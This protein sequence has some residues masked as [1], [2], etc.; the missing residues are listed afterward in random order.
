LKLEKKVFQKYQV[1]DKP[2]YFLTL[3]QENITKKYC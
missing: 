1:V 2:I 3:K